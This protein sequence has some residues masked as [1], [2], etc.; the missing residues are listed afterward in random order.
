M[1][2][3]A[4]TSS[5]F[6]FESKSCFGDPFGVSTKDIVID[7]VRQLP[8]EASMREMASEIEFVAGIRESM[9]EFDR[10][11]SVSAEELLRDI[12]QWAKN[13]K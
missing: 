9:D 11:D 12:P 13:S 6:L 5:L 4:K 3:F 10:G 7:L 8:E 2:T 1:P